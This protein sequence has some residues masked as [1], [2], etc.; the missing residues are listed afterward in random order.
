MHGTCRFQPGEGPSRGLLRNY[1]PL[2]GP[3]FEALV[4]SVRRRTSVLLLVTLESVS[5]LVWSGLVWAGLGWAGLG[6]AGLAAGLGWGGWEPSRQAAAGVLQ[7]HIPLLT[8]TCTQYSVDSALSP[9]CRFSGGGILRGLH[10][11]GLCAGWVAGY[12]RMQCCEC[13]SCLLIAD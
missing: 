6:W 5:G 13:V 12:C 4:G 3:S 2:C 11:S 10:N 9:V 7:H 8:N 1:E